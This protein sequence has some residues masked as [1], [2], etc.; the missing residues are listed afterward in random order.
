MDL[1]SERICRAL[2]HV[3]GQAR[4]A[5]ERLVPFAGET[6]VIAAAAL[7]SLRFAIEEDG[8]LQPAPIEGEPTLTIHVRAGALAALTRGIEHA[9]REIEV[10]G[11]ARLAAEVLFLARHL[12]WDAEE[13]LARVF[14]DA[15]AHRMTRDA[16]RLARGLGETARRLAGA[17]VDDALEERRLVVRRAEHDAL[18]RDNA[19]LRDALDRLEKRLERLA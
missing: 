16:R 9:T 19:R 18:A 12:R 8:L 13:D 6:L 14:G 3:L 2:N 4:W 11:N 17:L 10:T 5:R 7:P 1:L 15:L